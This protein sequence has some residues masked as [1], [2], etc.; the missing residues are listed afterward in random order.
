MNNRAVL[1]I[2]VAILA[3]AVGLELWYT[4]SNPVIPYAPTSFND[5]DLGQ[6]KSFSYIKDGEV[7][8]TYLYTVAVDRSASPSPYTASTH[9]DITY[10]G[11][12]IVLDTS[13]TFSSTMAPRFYRVRATV[14]GTLS[15]I[16]CSFSPESVMIV[17]TSGGKNQNLTVSLPAG[18]VVVDNNNPAHWEIL[19][20]SFK[21]RL[22][23]IY[24]MTAFVPQSGNVY[25]YQIGLDPS[26]KP[27]TIEAQSYNCVVV[28]EPDIGVVA[29]FYGGS[30]MRFDSQNDG[31]TIIR[32]P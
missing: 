9:S 15:T 2:G 31:V 7:I 26:T 21:P 16:A 5:T 8:G 4:N 14:N 11:S 27:V 17:N 18:T 28:R 32:T 6:V 19:Y 13:L 3:V 10:K 29:Y 25:D 24:G 1:I 30:L 23:K 12:H 20:R 22:G